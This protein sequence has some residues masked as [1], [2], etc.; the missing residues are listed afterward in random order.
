MIYTDKLIISSKQI[1]IM[2]L[3]MNPP[4]T[5]IMRKMQIQQRIQGHFSKVINS[6]KVMT[7]F[8]SL[9]TLKW[10]AYNIYFF[11]QRDNIRKKNIHI[12]QQALSLWLIVR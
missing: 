6:Y 10:L 7:P 9:F 3:V 11:K 4:V 8:P 5:C 1:E 2:T 12:K